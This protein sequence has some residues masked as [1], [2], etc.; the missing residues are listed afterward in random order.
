MR[1]LNQNMLT[2]EDIVTAVEHEPDI[3]VVV[4]RTE[5]ETNFED[6][7]SKKPELRV[8]RRARRAVT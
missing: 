1:L 3:N 8:V 2:G 6:K 5:R 4:V 7:L